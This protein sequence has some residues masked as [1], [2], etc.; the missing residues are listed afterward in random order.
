MKINI[1]NFALV[2]FLFSLVN[3]LK[4]TYQDEM[5]Q[6]YNNLIITPPNIE[7]NEN[8]LNDEVVYV[9]TPIDP[10]EYA[11]LRNEGIA[12]EQ[13]NFIQT[14]M[15][16]SDNQEIASKMINGTQMGYLNKIDPENID[17]MIKLQEKD[18]QKYFDTINNLGYQ[19]VYQN[20][21]NDQMQNLYS[22][23]EDKDNLLNYNNVISKLKMNYTNVPLNSS[24]NV[25][26]LPLNQKEMA[27]M[28]SNDFNKIN[29]N[30]KQEKINKII[31]LF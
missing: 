7:S 17:K 23:M 2:I 15:E 5:S 6:K 25:V 22:E 14:G 1:N 30:N 9:P 13:P 18:Y 10:Y 12:Q 19:K 11:K 27:D 21:N 31:F 29:L 26:N 16:Y 24:N 28:Y 4:Q 20:L 8:N 3:A